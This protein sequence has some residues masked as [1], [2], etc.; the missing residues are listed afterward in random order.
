MT[1]YS[2]EIIMSLD[3]G[4]R[5]S[6]A[7][8]RERYEWGAM[9]AGGMPPEINRALDAP[10]RREVDP[11]TGERYAR[12]T[13]ALPAEVSLGR[14]RELSHMLTSTLAAV[15]YTLRHDGR[16][17][18]TIPGEENGPGA[19]EVGPMAYGAARVCAGGC[20]SCVMAS[21]TRIGCCTQGAAFSLADLGAALLD[22]DEAFVAAALARP[23]EQDGAKYQTYLNGGVCVYHSPDRGCT[24]PRNRMPLQCRTYLCAPERLLPPDV[25]V[26][27]EAYVE[28]L[29]E[30]EDFVGGHMRE[31]SGVSFVS[32]LADLK[33]A[34]AKAWAA[35]AAQGLVPRE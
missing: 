10:L 3:D 8:W 6:R 13:L 31:E 24:L 17:I 4:E 15:G 34:A 26:E 23:G 32:S 27:Y 22:G 30:V 11:E 1:S 14:A 20:M 2:V 16:R 12:V 35:A 5:L 25:L 33:G 18:D 21:E 19:A 28:A 29:D 7:W 9:R